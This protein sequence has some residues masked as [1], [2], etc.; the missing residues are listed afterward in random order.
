MFCD[1]HNHLHDTRLDPW[2]EQITDELNRLGVRMV[3]N[4][5]SESDWEA[6]LRLSSETVLPS[7][8]LHPW[9]V[10]NRSEKWKQ[11]FERLLDSANCAVGEIGL[12]RWMENPDLS[13]QEEVFIT[14]L[15]MAAER[16][17]P[18]SIHCLKAWG[19]LDEILRREPRPAAGF[20]LHS[21]GGPL[22]M[23]RG[24]AELGGYFSLSGYFAH[25]RKARRREV[26]KAVPIDRLLLETDAPD[27]LPPENLN[28]YQLGALNHPGNIMNVY[29]FA[30]E[31]LGRAEAELAAI[32]EENF[33][34]L[35]G[36]LEQKNSNHLARRGEPKSTGHVADR[37]ITAVAVQPPI[38]R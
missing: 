13:A 22:E 14:Q 35:F 32:V 33:F 20:L 2:R 21:Y 12:D 4:G 7:I 5:A 26:F 10:A 9:Y 38:A 37:P 36:T 24:F 16:N 28:A 15:R 11:T 3:V 25:P 31:L 23:V 34:R 30:A 17:L 8:G 18:V 29:R 1:A 6:V 27:M 19:R